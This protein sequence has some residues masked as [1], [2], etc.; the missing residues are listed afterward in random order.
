MAGMWMAAC[1]YHVGVT[2]VETR[3][4]GKGPSLSLPLSVATETSKTKN[5]VYLDTTHTYIYKE[6]GSTE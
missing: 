4:E 2:N 5:C 3:G 1:I 6:Y